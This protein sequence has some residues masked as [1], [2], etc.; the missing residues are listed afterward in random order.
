MPDSGD[1]NRELHVKLDALIHASRIC[2]ARV[3]GGNAAAAFEGAFQRAL[4]ARPNLPARPAPGGPLVSAIAVILAAIA[5]VLAG[6]W[7]LR[8]IIRRKRS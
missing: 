6:E 4:A 7:L 3:I 5:M 1:S 8:R 2:W